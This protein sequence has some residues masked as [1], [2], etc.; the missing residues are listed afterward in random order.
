MFLSFPS[1]SRSLADDDTAR[2]YY[3]GEWLDIEN[4]A[5]TFNLDTPKVSRG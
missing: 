5:G 2:A 4:C 1:L 3:G